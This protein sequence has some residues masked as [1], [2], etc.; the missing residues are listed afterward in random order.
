MGSS[1]E[2][3]IFDQIR[4]N[5]AMYFCFGSKTAI[6]QVRKFGGPSRIEFL[7]VDRRSGKVTSYA[8]ALND[9]SNVVPRF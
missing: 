3:G 7:Y 8:L 5:D 2:N 6:G 4:A 9:D 1:R